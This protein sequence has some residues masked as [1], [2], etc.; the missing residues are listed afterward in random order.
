MGCAPLGVAQNSVLNGRIVRE[1]GFAR[2]HIPHCV[3]DEGVAVGCALFGAHL[4]ATERQQAAAAAP[5][6]APLDPILPAAA[7]WQEAPL[8]PPYLGKRYSANE[9]GGRKERNALFGSLALLNLNLSPCSK[10]WRMR[11][12]SFSRFSVK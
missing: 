10:R 6:A 11:S 12:R 7:A 4:L 3:G 9:V 1:C 8:V 5:A 2:V